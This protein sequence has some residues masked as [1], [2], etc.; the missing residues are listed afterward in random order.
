MSVALETFDVGDLIEVFSAFDTAT[1]EEA[2]DP[3]IVRCKIRDPLNVATTYVYGVDAELT[4]EGAG[5]YVLTIELSRVGVWSYRWEA[6]DTTEDN[7]TGASEGRFKVRPSDF[8][9][10]TVASGG[11]D[12]AIDGGTP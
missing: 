6:V 1:E 10:A 8:T 2:V 3:A 7:R 4:R 11:S 5:T 9:Y 12:D